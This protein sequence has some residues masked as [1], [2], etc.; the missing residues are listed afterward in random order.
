M[1]TITATPV[2]LTEHVIRSV[3]GWL[4]GLFPDGNIL[5]NRDESEEPS[6]PAFR[7]EI[8]AG[9]SWEESS[10]G[11]NW[12]TMSLIV[13]YAAAKADSILW[14]TERVVG[15]IRAASVRP[16]GR[17]PLRLYNLEWPQP[18]EITK[19]ADTGGTLPADIQV[20]VAARDGSD[21][22]GS[23]LSAAQALVVP[24]GAVVG[25]RPRNW[26]SGRP[27]AAYWEVYAGTTT[28]QLQGTVEDGDTFDLTEL[29]DG[30]TIPTNRA[31]AWDGLRVDSLDV[32]Q[33]EPGGTE[34]IMDA[35]ITLRLRARAA[36]TTDAQM[37]SELT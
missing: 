29:T 2:D 3:R 13:H 23:A 19:L 10:Q 37:D 20:A 21:N 30:P 14:D 4:H 6:R 15:K 31:L 5:L 34:R 26:P 36:R 25:I 18:P 7:L 33:T 8:A 22:G 1:T 12:L 17:I 28:L 16:Q 11:G 9:P 27:L 35:A 24:D 32:A